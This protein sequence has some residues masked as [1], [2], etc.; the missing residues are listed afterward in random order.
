MIKKWLALLAAMMLL[1]S[2]WTV[3]A[4][5]VIINKIEN[6]ENRFA[7]PEDAKL[8]EIYFPKIYD[9]AAAF[10]RYGEY[11]MLFDCGG[12]QWE[13]TKHLL[14]R[15][16][17]T[18]MTYACNSHPHTDHIYGYQ[19]VLKEIPAGMFQLFFDENYVH[20]NKCAFKIYDELHA[21]GVPF[22]RLYDGDTIPFGDVQMSILQCTDPEFTGN[23]QSA[24]LKVQLGERSFLFTSDI[25][26][27][28]QR[29]LAARNV[30]LRADIVQAPHHG[31]NRTQRVFLDA[32]APELV[33][34]T[35]LKSSANGV[36]LLKELNIDYLYTSQEIIKMTTDGEVWVVEYL[37]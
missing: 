12:G 2:T 14:D 10:I 3:A 29:K 20:A 21:M 1:V 19:F 26:M 5:E 6:P 11:S 23:N 27:D 15:L 33:I 9:C 4:E 7:F 18:E 28:A 16:G 8:L 35:S 25:Q 37:K 22:Q 24:L 30:D 31:Y 32:V 13:Q 17:V 36:K 34:V